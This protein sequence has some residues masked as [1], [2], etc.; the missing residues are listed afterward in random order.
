MRETIERKFTTYQG[1]AVESQRVIDMLGGWGKIEWGHY[2]EA[3]QKRTTSVYH[4]H[5]SVKMK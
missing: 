5:Y 4:C 2:I 1:V 3:F